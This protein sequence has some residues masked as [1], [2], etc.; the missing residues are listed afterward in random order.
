MNLD[1][2]L[3]ELET[4]K[5]NL[6]L[7]IGDAPAEVL[8]IIA[9]IEDA[10][11]QQEGDL[12]VTQTE[13]GYFGNIWVRQNYIRNAGISFP[14]HTHHF[15]HV[16]LLVRGK[17]RVD[18]EGHEPKEFTA[19][20]F[21]VVKK[22]LHHQITSLEDNV[23]YYC[24]FA[25]RDFD[26]EVM[27]IYGEQHDPRSYGKLADGSAPRGCQTSCNGCNEELAEKIMNA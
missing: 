24:V 3:S 6:F 7:K 4:I 13:L 5:R 11:L 26:G 22:E 15:D 17:V 10:K 16:T 12:P 18:I 14:G 2:T 25:I 21:I 1:L 27:D 23:L 20:T 9:K 8:P 19:P